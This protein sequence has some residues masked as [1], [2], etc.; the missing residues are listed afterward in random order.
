MASDVPTIRIKDGDRRTTIHCT[1]VT[2][3]L[4]DGRIVAWDGNAATHIG[5][6]HEGGTIKILGDAA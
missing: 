2:L 5:Y 1:A 4:V 6:L 3:E